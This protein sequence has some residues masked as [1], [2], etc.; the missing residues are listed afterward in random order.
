MRDDKVYKVLQ[1]R[2]C[3]ARLSVVAATAVQAIG[4]R[5]GDWRVN[6]AAF[7]PPFASCR[8]LDLPAA[9]VS[10]F[11]ELSKLVLS[12]CVGIVQP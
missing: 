5:I 2:R 12:P 9:L 1:G 11:D 7:P 10:Q 4:N 6:V 8:F 3:A